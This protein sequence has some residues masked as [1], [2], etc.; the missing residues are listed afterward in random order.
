[1]SGYISCREQQSRFTV[2]FRYSVKNTCSG[3]FVDIS[4]TAGIADND[5]GMG[6]SWADYNND[7][8]IYMFRTGSMIKIIRIVNKII[9]YTKITE[10]TFTNVTNTAKV[11]GIPTVQIIHL[12]RL[13]RVV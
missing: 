12:S 10:G 6:A 9:F 3:S 2:L 8:W 7:F 5:S 11:L 4:A 13:Y 1:M